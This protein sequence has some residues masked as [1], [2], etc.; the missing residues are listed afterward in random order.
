MAFPGLM[1]KVLHGLDRLPIYQPE[2]LLFT[3]HPNL[4][5]T[6]SFQVCQ[7]SPPSTSYILSD[8]PHRVCLTLICLIQKAP[9][10][11]QGR[12]EE[13][14][15]SSAML[16]ECPDLTSSAELLI[17]HCSYTFISFVFATPFI[18]CE[19]TWRWELCLLPGMY[20]VLSLYLLSEYLTYEYLCFPTSA[21]ACFLRGI[22]L[23]KKKFY[24]FLLL[25]HRSAWF[26]VN[27]GC[28]GLNTE[29]GGRLLPLFSS[30]CYWV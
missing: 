14:K 27:V 9:L 12:K 22:S 5:V 1:V 13:V 11:F 8:F 10:N 23:Q 4:L 2:N 15:S 20:Q 6:S 18:I 21:D 7:V 30:T 24:C 19:Q 17:L 16:L 29:E 28:A 26:Q 25:I 3:S